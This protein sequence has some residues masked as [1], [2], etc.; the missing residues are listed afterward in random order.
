MRRRRQRAQLSTGAIAMCSGALFLAVLALPVVL[1]LTWVT[2]A[3]DAMIG[4]LPEL[5]DGFETAPQRSIVL[6]RDG[7]RLA[8]L[9][10]ENRKAVPLE[11]I[12]EH[13]VNAVLATEDHTFWKHSGV[14]WV[15]IS[16]SALRLAGAG[17]AQGGGSTITQQV[18]KNRFVGAEQSLKR[19][20]TEA[21]LAA[22]VERQ[23][24]KKEILET[25]LN[26]TYFGNGV[27]GIATAAEYYWS[28]PID[29]LTPA[30][31]A[32]LA[33]IIRAP[34]KNNPVD[35]PDLAIR[36]RNIVLEQMAGAGMLSPDQAAKAADTPLDLKIK[37]T[38]SRGSPFVIDIIRRELEE[39]PALGDTPDERWNAALRGGFTIRTTLHAGLQRAAEETIKELLTNKKKDPLAAIVAV[40]PSTGDVIAAAVGP[41]SYGEG[42]G[43]TTINPAMPGLGG[44]GRQPGSTF[45]A[46]ELVAALEHEVSPTHMFQSGPS[47]TSQHPSCPNYDVTNYGG[48]D[49]GALDMAGLKNWSMWRTAW[50]SRATSSPTAPP[51]WGPRASSPWRWRRRSAPWPTRARTASH[52]RCGPSVRAREMS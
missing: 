29:A 14:N 38:K 3:A 46:F 44:M 5:P 52:T 2:N 20:V 43:K 30:Q 27:Y 21:A 7:K 19:K 31:G 51:C 48:A 16:R 36:R 17:E 49:L 23:F 1:A 18:V 28:K 15:G 33:G 9:Q 47:Y 32:L 25:Y 41:K 40:E 37:R 42:P 4:D 34:E 12:P 8:T 6:D 13:V 11:K 24:T 22:Q 45:K 26:D 10:V 35:A 50:A 39:D